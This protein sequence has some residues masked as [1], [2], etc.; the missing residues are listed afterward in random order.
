M[1]QQ[2]G[3][4]S[5]A[6]RVAVWLPL[7]I[8]GCV[9]V[10]GF[11]H[12]VTKTEERRSMKFVVSELGGVARVTDDHT[13]IARFLGWLGFSEFEHVPIEITL[14]N[15]LGS[16]RDTETQPSTDDYRLILDCDVTDDDVKSIARLSSVVRLDL[17]NCGVTEKC[18]RDLL[19]LR[20]LER[21][22]LSGTRIG[23]EGF[24]QL[25]RH[26]TLEAL[27]VRY[28]G[29]DD[30]V[31]GSIVGFRSL[32]KLDIGFNSCSNEGILGIL[33]RLPQLQWIGIDGQRIS[34]ESL[35]F[36]R[37]EFPL[38][39]V[40]LNIDCDLNN[41]VAASS[42]RLSQNKIIPG[43]PVWNQFPTTRISVFEGRNDVSV[44]G[45]GFNT[46]QMRLPRQ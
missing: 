19:V 28:I 14:D 8:L 27:E 23:L 15:S 26:P 2:S 21:L 18:V 3:A 25:Q 6:A 5:V 39:T 37:S 38:V 22:N 29:L 7:V 42:T 44:K 31:V 16:E 12:V 35:K 13:P 45:K 24:K 1:N 17:C 34:A 40:S 43:V 33:S 10:I 4:G 11:C 20:K 32:K 36:L 9:A 46:P 30:S 41:A